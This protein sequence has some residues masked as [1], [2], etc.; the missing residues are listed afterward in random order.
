MPVTKTT[1]VE[2]EGRYTQEGGGASDFKERIETM[3]EMFKILD[4]CFGDQQ[5]INFKE[6]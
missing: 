5:H 3:Q 6:F 1:V 4:I 2:G